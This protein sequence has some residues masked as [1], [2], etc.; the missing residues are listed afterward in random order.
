MDKKKR[1]IIAVGLLTITATVV[2]VWGMY[3][4]LGN[5]ILRGGMDIVIQLQ[6]GAGLKRGDRVFLLG[7]DVGWVQAVDLDRANRVVVDTRLRGDL[8]L[9]ADTRASVI[10]DVFGAHSVQLHPGTAVVR[11]ESSDTVRGSAVPQITA[12]AADLSESALSVLGRADSLLSPE[13]VRDVHAVAAELP[14]SAAELRSA[15]AE[16]RLAAAALRR[17][18]EGVEQAR[19]GDAF[20]GAIAG[21]ERAADAMTSAARTMETSLGSFASVMQKIDSGRGTLGRLVNDE[22]LYTTLNQTVREMGQLAQDIRERPQRYIS[23]R[24]F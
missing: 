3:Y 5:P 6:D 11:L 20:A 21:V 9:P 13:A 2:F 7:V 14:A 24:I 4:L 18:V 10:G 23:I 12:L 15:L 19:T 1:N 16:F 8:S 17:T 22:S